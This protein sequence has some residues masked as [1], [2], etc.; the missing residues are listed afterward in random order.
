MI[1]SIVLPLRHADHSSLASVLAFHAVKISNAFHGNDVL[2][3]F[4]LAKD[5]TC[6]VLSK[7]EISAIPDGIVKA[8]VKL[9][10]T[11]KLKHTSCSRVHR[12]DA[13][14]VDDMVQ[15]YVKN[16]RS[17]RGSWSSPRIILSIDGEAGSVVVSARGGKRMFA[18][19]EE[20]ILVPCEIPLSTMFQ[21]AIDK[22][23]SY[24]E[25]LINVSFSID[26][27]SSSQERIFQD[28][29]D[30][31]VC[32]FSGEKPLQPGEGDRFEIFWPLDDTSYR[33]KVTSIGDDGRCTIEYDEKVLDTLNMFDEVWRFEQ[34][35]VNGPKLSVIKTL[36]SNERGALPPMMEQLGLRYFLLHHTQ[37]FEQSVLLNA[38]ECEESKYV[39]TV[40]EVQRRM[41]LVTQ[42]L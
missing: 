39:T 11:R 24:I 23:D 12:N 28:G 36:A 13:V 1:R 29:G 41:V 5:F 19:L 6:F 38:Y 32:A 27:S 21:A 22:L 26:T 4:E 3:L 42:T 15:V 34:Q 16:Y 25:E 40:K 8:H 17:K 18:T 7:T 33:G 30:V 31:K 10:A 2:F 9:S 14:R 37:V 20:V 35:S